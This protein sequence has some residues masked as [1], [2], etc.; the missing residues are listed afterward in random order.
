RILLPDSLIKDHGSGYLAFHLRGL[1][2]VV[3][4]VDQCGLDT[5]HRV[6]GLGTELHGVLDAAVDARNELAR[7]ASGRDGILE[8]VNRI[9]FDLEGLEGDLDLRELSRSTRL[10]LVGVIVLLDSATDGLTVGDLGLAHVG[11]DL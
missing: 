8:L 9:A 11:L 2:V 1:D 10:L 6:T 3:S 5:D 7:N 4:A